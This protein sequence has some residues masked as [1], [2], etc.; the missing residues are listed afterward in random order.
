MGTPG[1]LV[2]AEPLD[3]FFLSRNISRYN[4]INV[5]SS[6]SKHKVHSILSTFY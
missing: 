3:L 1:N 6:L 2:H 5:G 4:L